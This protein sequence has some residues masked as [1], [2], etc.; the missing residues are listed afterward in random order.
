MPVI[1]QPS[2]CCSNLTLASVVIDSGVWPSLP[3]TSESAIE[4]Q[5]AC[6]APISS[7]GLVPAPSC[8]RELERVR[9]LEA[10]ERHP[11]AA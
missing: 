5:P 3:S 8:M 7:S 9:A 2:P 10:A 6:A 11:A 4:K 1:A